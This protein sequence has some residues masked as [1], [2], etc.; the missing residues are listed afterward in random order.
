[1]HCLCFGMH[2][3][4]GNM[5]LNRSALN[6]LCD[7]YRT[8]IMSSSLHHTNIK[9]DFL[10]RRTLMGSYGWGLIC[11]ECMLC[12]SNAIAIR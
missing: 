4:N 5:I 1:M 12:M 8:K 3:V 9:C 7:N 10:Y 11:N 6:T 2:M